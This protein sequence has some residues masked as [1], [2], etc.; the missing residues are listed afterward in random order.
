M[1]LLILVFGGLASFMIMSG[2]ASY[3]VFESR[4]SNRLYARDAAFHIAEAGAN[5]YR[6]HLAHNPTDYTDGTAGA[7]PYE[8]EYRDKDGNLIGYYTLIVDEPLPGSTIVT[9]RSIGRTVQE[10]NTQRTIQIRVGFPSVAN[11]TFLQHENMSFSPTSIVQGRVHANGGIEFNGTTNAA[12]ESARET[13]FTTTTGNRPGVWGNGGP[14][15]FWNF[16]VPAIDFSGVS[17]DLAAIQD[18]AMSDGI[19]L[20][21][22]GAEGWQL[23]F[24][25]N[26]TFNLYRVNNRRG[27]TGVA[28]C[29]N[30]PT[31]ACYPTLYHDLNLNTR[32]FIANYPIPENGAVFVD[33]HVWVEGTVNGRVTVAAGRFPIQ[34]S[35]YRNIM[36]SGNLVYQAQG[37]D[38]VIGLLAQGSII[39][40]REVPQDMTIHAAALAQNGQITRPHYQNSTRNSLTFFGSQMSAVNGG[41]KVINWAGQV[42]AGF[43]NTTH[44]YD[45]NL[46]YY[47]PP[48]FPVGNTYDLLSWEEVE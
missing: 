46:L 2:I 17:A 9:V 40:P 5:Y 13:Y 41:W 25:A 1:L 7:G 47:I 3:A 36:I 20:T 10:P 21:S 12:V 24:L 6:W 23:V 8:H 22:S 31:W 37:S 48:G 16:P 30:N 19:H 39:V 14:T 34:T 27:F 15:T 43:I 33:D 11:Y 45:G 44:I 38:D 32:T 26:G 35:T 42:I 4:A 28:P 18:L 29:V